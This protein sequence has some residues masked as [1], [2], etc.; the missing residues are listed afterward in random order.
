MM[1]WPLEAGDVD[2]LVGDMKNNG[3]FTVLPRL[4]FAQRENMV[5]GGICRERSAMQMANDC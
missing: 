4:F 5:Q 1:N 3:L 2:C